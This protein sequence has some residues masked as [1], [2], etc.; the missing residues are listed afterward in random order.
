MARVGGNTNNVPK[1][2]ATNINGIE[3]LM[4]AELATMHGPIQSRETF[5]LNLCCFLLQERYHGHTLSEPRT[6][7]KKKREK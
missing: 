3:G 7:K 1:K 5:P 4:P 6:R 2:H